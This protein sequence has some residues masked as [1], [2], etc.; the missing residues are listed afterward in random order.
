MAKNLRPRQKAFNGATQARM[1]ALNSTLGH[2]KS[3]KAL[4]WTETIVD[5]IQGLRTVEQSAAAYLYWMRAAHGIT[6]E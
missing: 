1:S 3:L 2:M 4:G 5:Y 6:G